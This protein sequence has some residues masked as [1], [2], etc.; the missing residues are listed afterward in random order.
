M[1][2]NNYVELQQS[3]TLISRNVAALIVG[4][5]SPTSE[6]FAICRWIRQKFP[7]LC[8]VFISANYDNPIFRADAAFNGVSACLS[9]GTCAA[10]LSEILQLVMQG[11]TLI[12]SDSKYVICESITARELDVLRLI[13]CGTSDKKI[14]QSLQ[15]SL[16]TA[17]THVK[18]IL[19]KMR[20][21]NRMD[22][23]YRARHFGWM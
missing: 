13:G 3:I 12:L 16:P 7:K 23:V 10:Q 9:A 19:R 20:V 17:Q 14:A 5:Q 11:C 8:I 18:H 22:A 1:A 15:V 2:V 6:G 4:P 21:K